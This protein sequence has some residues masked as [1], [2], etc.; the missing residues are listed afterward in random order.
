MDLTKPAFNLFI[1]ESTAQSLVGSVDVGG[2][3][4]AA[5]HMRH[6]V[7]ET[8]IQSVLATCA[9][10]PTNS[11]ARVLGVAYLLAFSSAA[12]AEV[13]QMI[14]SLNLGETPV[15]HHFGGQAR[16]LRLACVSEPM[17]LW[18]GWAVENLKGN[19]TTFDPHMITHLQSNAGVIK[20]SL[21]SNASG[22]APLAAP[23][24]GQQILHSFAP[25]GL[26][27][28]GAAVPTGFKPVHTRTLTPTSEGLAQMLKFDGYYK[29]TFSTSN[30][31]SVAGKTFVGSPRALELV[32]SLISYLATYKVLP[33]NYPQILAELQQDYDKIKEALKHV[34]NLVWDLTQRGGQHFQDL[35]EQMNQRFADPKTAVVASMVEAITEARTGW[36]NNRSILL[37]ALDNALAKIYLQTHEPLNF[38]SGPPGHPASVSLAPNFYLMGPYQ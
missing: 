24:P 33:L 25:Q 19:S 15:T 35:R 5:F 18:S 27:L 10:T 11:Y 29:N 31:A 17:N 26:S 22:A 16:A 14:G 28:Q 6:K 4:S 3:L 8:D 7:R 1:A 12:Y 34:R 37:Q 21:P 9:A 20:V 13:A 36:T 38:T 32:N 2:M 30:L 23:T